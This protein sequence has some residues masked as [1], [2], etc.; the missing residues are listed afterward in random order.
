MATFDIIFKKV[1]I[2]DLYEEE[3]IPFKI[4]LALTPATLVDGVYRYN[5]LSIPDDASN[6][7]DLFDLENDQGVIYQAFSTTG[8]KLG[9]RVMYKGIIEVGWYDRYCF[10]IYN[11]EIGAYAVQSGSRSDVEYEIF[12]KANII[13]NGEYLGLSL[14]E[15]FS[16]AENRWNLK[17]T[18]YKTG[19][20]NNRNAFMQMVFSEIDGETTIWK[21][22]DSSGLSEINGFGRLRYFSS[23]YKL[24][25]GE[26]YKQDTLKSFTM[27]NG[28]EFY[29]GKALDWV[30]NPFRNIENFETFSQNDTSYAFLDV[31]YGTDPSFYIKN[32]EDGKT[33]NFANG[34]IIS[35]E[36]TEDR[37]LL[38]TFSIV[39][40]EG[41]GETLKI[42]QWSNSLERLSVSGSGSRYH[43]SAMQKMIQEVGT[44]N[45]YENYSDDSA[46]FGPMIFVSPYYNDWNPANFKTKLL[47]ESHT[48][49]EWK[50]LLARVFTFTQESVTKIDE[51]L[52]ILYDRIPF[53]DE[54]TT[55]IFS[56]AMNL[57]ES[58]SDYI[59]YC[60]TYLEKDGVVQELINFD[61]A[62][63]WNVLINFEIPNKQPE[64]GG[65]SFGGV[66]G[67]GTFDDS[68]SIINEPELPFTT[69][70]G[71]LLKM[72]L[73]SE[74]TIYNAAYKLNSDLLSRWL[75]ELDILGSFENRTEGI[76][77]YKVVFSPV[78]PTA[79]EE[80]WEIRGS[81]VKGSSDTAQ[82]VPAI[83]S[84]FIKFNYGDFSIEPYFDNFLD[85]E[86]TSIKIY[87][88]FAGV[89]DIDPNL[90]F[91]SVC[92]LS[93][94]LN[95]LTGDIVYTIKV[96]K[97]KMESVIYTFN[98]NSAIDLPLTSSDYSGK[99]TGLINTSISMVNNLTNP[100]TTKLDVA[101]TAISGV[102]ALKD[103][104]NIKTTGV[105]AKQYG[106]MAVKIPYMI[107]ERPKMQVP[108]N[109][110][111]MYGWKTAV[112]GK[113]GDYIGMTVVK[114]VHLEGLGTATTNEIAEIESIL[115]SGVIL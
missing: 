110:G 41:E 56:G 82:S 26:F 78:A 38:S 33:V 28:S 65:G 76:V 30:E 66:G 34:S 13:I 107:I 7:Y 50:K 89:F 24:F 4:G 77:S 97:G 79:T 91:E 90:M 81:E 48:P 69:I 62:E 15:K 115:K 84:Q 51:Y 93:M 106:Q 23:W 60:T 98:G 43:T 25:Y 73:V 74:G 88:P 2:D 36:V 92:N 80:I 21:V 105:V 8:E 31:I 75:N 52:Q 101:K 85:V 96:K 55:V 42:S 10:M 94:I 108:N 11:E 67:N 83:T 9:F 47:E 103:P 99:V 5:E 29:F 95:F 63:K 61:S 14:E 59:F 57:F 49:E 53:S 54:R 112:G 68:S 100:F 111:K 19:M 114:E 20:N 39:D 6:L 102:K 87:L 3:E 37:K 1:L 32:F 35:L 104:G 12:P 46:C 17:D 45:L 70:T 22:S 58:G 71:N 16:D 40:V 64:T 109:F 27:I 86:K 72:W 18:I 113:L 44:R